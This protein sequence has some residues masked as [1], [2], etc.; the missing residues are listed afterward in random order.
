MS[1]IM[2]V[3]NEPD[4]EML[5][6]Q[7]FR[8]EIK[9]E[10]LTFLFSRD[11]KEAF[12]EV[13]SDSEIEVV[14]TDVNVK[15][16]DGFELLSHLQKLNRP[17]KSIL[18]SPY[19]DLNAIR[20]AMNLGAF[21]FVTR[22]INLDELDAAVT[23]ALHQVEETRKMK[24]NQERLIDIEKELDVA[25][26]I[27]SSIIP[28][29]FD[30]IPG[31][32]SFEILGSMTPA[33]HI[34]G[35]FFDFFPLP[36]NRLGFSIADVSGKGIP[37][38][39]FMTMSRGLLRSL[40]QKSLSPLECLTQLNTLLSVE[41]ES[42][43]FVTAFYGIY[44]YEKGY[45]TYCNA[46]HNPPYLIRSSGQLEQIGR[47]EGIALGVTTDLI[48][49]QEHT[50]QI[51]PGDTLLLYTDGVTEAMNPTRHLFGEARLE[52]S[53]K[54]HKDAPLPDLIRGVIQDVDAFSNGREQAD[55]LTL[56]AIRAT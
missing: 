51:K 16:M 18:V 21:D 32:T 33:K 7:K 49:Y 28:H 15:T 6:E 2:V 3:N 29:N 35:D 22:P 1:K 43:M 27:Q 10:K 55:D 54:A 47:S 9:Q 39:L 46:G 50:L 41:N 30:P 24:K 26:S 14:I 40:G 8:N 17:L 48:T 56:L 5:I 25:K 11:G 44:D 42:S 37:A 38:A 36:D 23:K 19:G 34:G 20:Q 31:N 52:S 53:L 45:I 12:Q 4:L 13:Q